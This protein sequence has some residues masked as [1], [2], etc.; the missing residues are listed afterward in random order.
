MH[1]FEMYCQFQGF[2]I[3]PS[4]HDWDSKK[5]SLSEV[6]EGQNWSTPIGPAPNSSSLISSV[7]PDCTQLN[8][9]SI[10]AVQDTKFVSPFGENPF[11]LQEALEE[12]SLESVLS[13]LEARMKRVALGS[14][15][16]ALPSTNSD[17]FQEPSFQVAGNGADFDKSE[18]L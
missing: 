6:E 10:A 15:V 2:P 5:L 18:K 17:K 16:G 12:S 9:P 7:K 3:T 13:V 8:P 14:K 11:A 4:R 1:G